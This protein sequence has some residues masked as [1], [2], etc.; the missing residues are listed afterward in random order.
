MHALVE[1][2]AVEEIKLETAGMIKELFKKNMK[3]ADIL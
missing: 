3:G 1:E 2:K